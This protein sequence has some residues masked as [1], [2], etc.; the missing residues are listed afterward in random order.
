[1]KKH[2]RKER[3]RS[4]MAETFKPT[5]QAINEVALPLSS[6]FGSEII[7]ILHVA[8]FTQISLQNERK[9]GRKKGRKKERKKEERKKERKKERKRKKET[10]RERDQP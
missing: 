1:M 4:T 10:K 5:K 9:K 2:V 6:T 3:E 7:V 8:T